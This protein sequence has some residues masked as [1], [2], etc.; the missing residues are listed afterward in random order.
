MAAVTSK[1][2]VRG[3]GDEE[4]SG[5]TPATG[6]ADY[7]NDSLMTEFI[8]SEGRAG[9][10]SGGNRRSRGIFPGGEGQ[11]EALESDLEKKTALHRR[12]ARLKRSDLVVAVVLPAFALAEIGVEIGE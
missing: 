9:G 5:G 6:L 4:A 7:Q 2:R 11:V 3:S 10:Q 1:R 12:Q 8:I